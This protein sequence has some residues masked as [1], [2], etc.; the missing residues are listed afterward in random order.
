MLGPP[1]SGKSLLQSALAGRLKPQKG[2]LNIQGAVTYNG[3]D[4][5][6]LESGRIVGWVRQR[7]V[8]LPKL[9]VLETTK[10]AMDCLLDPALQHRILSA[11]L[12]GGGDSDASVGVDNKVGSKHLETA[13]VALADD[14]VFEELVS[15]L[16]K[17]KSAGLAALES[18]QAS[19]IEEE[20]GGGGGR[21]S[22]KLP[23]I[24]DNFGIDNEQ[25]DILMYV[26]EMVV[27]LILPPPS[28]HIILLT[29]LSSLP[30]P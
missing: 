8:H 11:L 29:P 17:S 18:G 10:F 6:T 15:K 27:V 4:V 5:S 2:S 3:I 23:G 25:R 9:S 30:F 22:S 14:D 24:L 20:K 19:R 1:G 26:L 12:V 7:D 13:S 16:S 21:E 28:F